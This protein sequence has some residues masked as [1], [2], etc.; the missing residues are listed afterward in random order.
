MRLL[1]DMNLPPSLTGF[2]KNQG[3]ECRHWKE[4][5]DGAAPDS[6]VLSWAAANGFVV[7]THDLDFSAILA[8][9]GGNAPSV[10][11]VKTQ[12]VLSPEFRQT[13]AGV[14]TRFSAELA[15]GAIV[16]VDPGRARVR[17]LP[18]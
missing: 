8:A 17:I 6:Q 16:T 14:L 7:V 4:V 10:I 12:D 5:G 13:L 11:Q 9:T 3:H 15:S 18:V 2:F 1:L